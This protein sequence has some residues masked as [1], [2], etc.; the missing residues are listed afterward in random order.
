MG[1]YFD[2]LLPNSVAGLRRREDTQRSAA[3][4]KFKHDERSVSFNL[5]GFS[6]FQV[7]VLR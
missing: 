3:W 6:D 7:G 4:R 1:G 2:A 5:T